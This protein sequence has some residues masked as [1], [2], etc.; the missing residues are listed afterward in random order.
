[1]TARLRRAASG[2]VENLFASNVGALAIAR[3]APVFVSITIAVAPFAPH[4][5]IACASSCSAFAWSWWSSVRITFCPAR[6]ARERTTSTGAAFG[7]THHDL[8]SRP[9]GE[10]LV[11][12]ALETFEASVVRPRVSDDVR[13]HRALWVRAPLLGVEADAR[14]AEPLERAALIGSA[15]RSR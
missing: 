9:A 6:S 1:M 2:A 5:C 14:E 4:S 3:I 10:P 8:E 7:V 12:R 13:G 11:E 15:F